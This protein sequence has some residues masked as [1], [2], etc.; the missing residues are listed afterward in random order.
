MQMETRLEAMR[1]LS[2]KEFLKKTIL[3]LVS[4]S[5]TFAFAGILSAQSTRAQELAEKQEEKSTHL[6]PYVP[7]K[8]ERIL[9][10]FENFL[11][12]PDKFYPFLG[13]TY[14]SGGFALGA[15]YRQRYGDTGWWDIH[16]AYSIRNYKMLDTTLHLPELVSGALKTDIN[17]HYVDATRVRF[18]GLG[19]DSR[20][21]NETNYGFEPISVGVT[22]TAR[23]VWWFGL[24]GGVDYLKYETSEGDGP[25]PSTEE[26]FDSVTAPGLG[27]DFEYLRPRA[28]VQIDWRQSPGY[29]TSG[30]LYRAAW[31]KYLERDLS[32]FDFDRV[33]IEIDQ[34]IP[35]F[36]ANWVIALRGLI[37][38][39]NVDSGDQIP[40]FLL[41]R[42]GGSSELRGYP[43]FRFIDR[44][45]LLLTAEYRW[46]PSKFLDMAIFYEAGKV[47]SRRA[48]L[49]L[50]D[51]HESYGI[52]ARFHAPRI[53]ALRIELARSIEGTRII[54]SGGPSF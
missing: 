3:L 10:R 15:G 53:T 36:R 44:H 35:L 8:G 20:Q 54:I 7:N 9:K 2:V 1:M 13:S 23:P 31:S 46:T 28:F 30:G 47:A 5:L 14:P 25:T 39:T 38:T 16:G 6:A 27:I 45:R 4:L 21:D 50:E 34:F 41:P 48:D 37:S 43:N 18:F 51:L 49:D 42:L 17:V 19:N 40:F 52:G 24:G 22:E 12:A 11:Q 29:T 33:D 26:V 32:G